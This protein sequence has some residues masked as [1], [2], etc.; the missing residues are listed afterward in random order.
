MMVMAGEIRQV[1]FIAMRYSFLSQRRA[2]AVSKTEGTVIWT[3]IVDTPSIVPLR[4][5]LDRCAE[6]WSSQRLG[7]R[8][9][10]A[11]RKGTLPKFSIPASM[12]AFSNGFRRSKRCP[13][14]VLCREGNTN[15]LSRV[16]ASS[17][18]RSASSSSTSVAL[19]FR[20]TDRERR[21]MQ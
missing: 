3:T 20:C 11:P 13:F 17:S 7:G 6:R 9:S 21:V 4:P 18:R 5:I 14:G 15:L 16:R 19:A 10:S 2:P 12:Q 8:A 1:S